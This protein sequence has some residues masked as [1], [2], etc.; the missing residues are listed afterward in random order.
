MLPFSRL[1]NFG[2]YVWLGS[3]MRNRESVLKIGAS[4]I[5]G[6]ILFFPLDQPPILVC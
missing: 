4:A 5:T 6:S 3:R 1:S 2:I